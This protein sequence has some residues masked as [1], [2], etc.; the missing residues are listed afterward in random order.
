M[1]IISDIYVLVTPEFL[2]IS[3]VELWFCSQQFPQFI[4]GGAWYRLK[5]ILKKNEDKS[6]V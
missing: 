4:F 1:C 6:L 2:L 5:I 3:M